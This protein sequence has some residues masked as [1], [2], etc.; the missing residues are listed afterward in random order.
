MIIKII[1]DNNI[2]IVFIIGKEMIISHVQKH[3]M[4]V[5]TVSGKYYSDI[6]N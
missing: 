2:D 3:I 6:I 5:S 1:G 4:Q